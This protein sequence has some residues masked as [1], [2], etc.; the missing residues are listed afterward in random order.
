MLGR[1]CGKKKALK[2]IK[3]MFGLGKMALRFLVVRVMLRVGVDVSV[4]SLHNT[5]LFTSADQ[6]GSQP[7]GQVENIK[8]TTAYYPTGNY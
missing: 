2:W 8:F 1:K 4:S 5:E 3:V 7:R 6:G